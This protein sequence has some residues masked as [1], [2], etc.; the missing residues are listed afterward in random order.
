MKRNTA[1]R[2]RTEAGF[3]LIELVVVLLVALLLG[4]ALLHGPKL[5]SPRD[6]HAAALMVRAEMLA[7]IARAEAQE[8]DAVFYVDPAAEGE[9]RGGFIALAGPPG[10]TRDTLS[11]SAPSPRAGLLHGAQWGWGSAPAGPDGL[12]PARMPG[13]IRC[14]AGL[15]CELGGTDHVVLYLT[16]ARNPHAV[17]AIVL[18]ADMTVHLLHFQPATGRWVDGLQ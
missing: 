16:H 3:T 6:V 1:G 5:G 8:G 2:R 4:A 13:T 9:S 12:P 10:S 14:R 11:G 7:A 17:D 18:W 15:T